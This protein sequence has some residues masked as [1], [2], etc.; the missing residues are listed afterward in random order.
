M[1][2]TIR[3]ATAYVSSP[4]H[5]DVHRG[6][7]GSIT[8]LVPFN[9]PPDGPVKVTLYYDTEAH[10][11]WS[12]GINV[13]TLRLI[14]CHMLYVTFGQIRLKFGVH[15]EV[16]ILNTD[17]TLVRVD[18]SIHLR[19]P[20]RTRANGAIGISIELTLNYGRLQQPVFS[21]RAIELS[22]T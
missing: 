19:I 14:D 12:R 1:P 16:T 10:L 6:T 8:N 5:V 9:P 4:Q 11:P 13:K 3:A 21:C 18:H 2:K 20:R 15:D 22:R 17:T 7:D